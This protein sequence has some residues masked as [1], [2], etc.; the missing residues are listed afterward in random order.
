MIATN[1]AITG[2]VIGLASGN[3]W[4]AIP[5]ALLSHFICDALPHFGTNQAGDSY[6]RSKAF[7]IFLVSDAL[8][9]MLL[10]ALLAVLQPEHWFLASVSA[11]VAT[12]P[13]FAWLPG[14]VRA[15][16]GKPYSTNPNWFLR[17]AADI[18]WFE[19]PIGAVVEVGWFLAG[20]VI[21]TQYL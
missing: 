14:Y 6:L 19:R 5:A 15:K 1:H 17:F 8:A 12:T 13:D 11:F 21:L 4:V 18:Q 9:C 3:V 7:S 20:M 2:A 10:V 16:C